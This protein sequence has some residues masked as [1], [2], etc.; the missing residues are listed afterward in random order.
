MKIGQIAT[1]LALVGTIAGATVTIEARYAQDEDLKQV[2]ARL[3]QKIKQDRCNYLQSWLWKLMD[4][5][6]ASCG[7]EADTCRRIRREMRT[8]GCPR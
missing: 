1:A 5:Y 3:D 4:R 7:P 2:A 8:L 6:G